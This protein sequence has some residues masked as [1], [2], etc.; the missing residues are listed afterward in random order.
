MQWSKTILLNFLFIAVA[1]GLIT[2]M[3]KPNNKKLERFG[4][5]IAELRRE[6]RLSIRELA[7]RS[8]IEHKQI[9]SIELNKTSIRLD[10]LFKL[11]DGLEMHPKDLLDFEMPKQK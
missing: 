9:N 10:T 2:V 8:G 11:A 4:L 7:L 6:R 3:D 1:F 5:H